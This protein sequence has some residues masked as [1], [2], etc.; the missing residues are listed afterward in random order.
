MNIRDIIHDFS[1]R[2]SG[3]FIHVKMPNKDGTTLCWCDQVVQEGD[4]GEIHLNSEEYGH[5]RLNINTTHELIFKYPRTGVFQHGREA[6]VFHRIPKRQ[7]T[8][9]LCSNNASILPVTRRCVSPRNHINLGHGT[10]ALPLVHS[11][12][13]GQTFSVS[14]A[15]EMLANKKARSVALPNDFALSLSFVE[16]PNYFLFYMDI[17]VA[18]V[19]KEGKVVHRY[20]KVYSAEI[21]E[22]FNEYS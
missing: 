7:W 12:F 20:E 21:E 22:M 18:R 11:A 1:R 5:L 6:Y 9:G 15:L 19:N 4:G 2:Y 14:T 13:E 8:K 16:D 10:Q 17:P 3:S